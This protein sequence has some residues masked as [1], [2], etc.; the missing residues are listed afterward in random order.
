MDSHYGGVVA[1][2]KLDKPTS[3]Y[4][5]PLRARQAA[6]TRRASSDV[7]LLRFGDQGWATTTLAIIAAQAG[8]SVDTVYAVFGTKSNLML[9]VVDVA[10]VGDDGEAAMADRPDFARFAEGTGIE[11]IRTGVHYTVEVFRRSLPI[12]RALQEA[13]ASDDAARARLTR[14]NEDRHDLTAAGL[15]LILDA[16]PSED[17]VDAVWA[18]LSPEVFTHLTEG[19]G[20]P[21]EKTEAWL[22]DM[23]SAA[24]EH[25]G[26]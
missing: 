9:A 23:A 13:A 11:R 3:R 19:R 15:A 22:V 12:L 10:I 8:T 25:R 14:Y 26:H 16:E 7:S 5:S 18:L 4:H 6:E 1:S 21:L 17:V 20:W 2:H 24:I